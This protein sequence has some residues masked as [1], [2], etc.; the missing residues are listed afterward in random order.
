MNF[1]LIQL[2]YW[3][4]LSCIRHFEVSL[5]PWLYISCEIINILTVLL[6]LLRCVMFLQRMVIQKVFPLLAAEFQNHIMI[7][8]VLPNVLLI[9]EESSIQEFST[10]MLP[11][12]RPVFTIQNPIQVRMYIYSTYARMVWIKNCYFMCYKSF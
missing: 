10:L 9:A 2:F 8:F 4:H 7:P 5:D 12:L 3:L 6:E 11:A 1:K